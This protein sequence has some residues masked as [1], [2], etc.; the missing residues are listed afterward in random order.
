MHWY[1]KIL[2]ACLGEFE[3]REK[4][5]FSILQHSHDISSYTFY[6]KNYYLRCEY[7]SLG[8]DSFFVFVMR[9]H[10]WR[11][12]Q[13]KSSKS[14][15]FVRISINISNINIFVPGLLL[16]E[17]SLS[18][19]SVFNNYS[20]FVNKESIAQEAGKLESKCSKRI[21]QYLICSRLVL[22]KSRIVKLLFKLPFC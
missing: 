19:F 22:K 16:P 8:K 3:W 17:Y 14:S 12:Y 5:L 11:Y 9:E 2:S 10:I 1:L 13:W 7:F 21:T 6:W 18:N 20:E 4:N 15:R